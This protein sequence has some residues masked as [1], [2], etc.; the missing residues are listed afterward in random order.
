MEWHDKTCRRLD[1]A[2]FGGGTSCLSCGSVR[3][4]HPILPVIKQPSDIRILRVLPG[5]F[6]D[7]V[8]CEIQTEDLS[9]DIDYEAISYTWADETGDA[10]HCR[11]ISVSG[12]PFKITRNCEMALKRVRRQ[13]STR[14][15]WVDAICINQDDV[16]ERGH[17]VGLMP[18]IYSGA[19]NVL[20]YIGEI[21]LCS[22][23][24]K[25]MDVQK[26]LDMNF[27]IPQSFWTEM[28]SSR[29]FTRLWVL[30]EVAL[31][32]QAVL[33]FGGQS[34]SWSVV[35]NQAEQWNLKFTPSVFHFDHKAYS[36]PVQ[37]INLL[38][39]AKSCNASDPRDKIFALLGLLPSR[40]IGDI[41]ADYSLTTED[42]YTRV[43]LHLAST[44]GWL[45][46]LLNAGKDAQKD[47][48]I[49]SLPSWVPDWSARVRPDSTLAVSE[50]STIKEMKPLDCI[51]HESKKSLSL[52]LLYTPGLKPKWHRYEDYE[53]LFRVR[54]LC[55]P[56][57]L[58]GDIQLTLEYWWSIFSTSILRRPIFEL[59]IERHSQ[60]PL[61]ASE[62]ISLRS[63]DLQSQY[64]HYCPD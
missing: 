12:Q 36:T 30:Q 38:R 28:L 57:I 27:P 3:P 19:K 20:M 53:A 63:L 4:T 62:Y 8:E 46:V 61:A 41:E 52:R 18:R 17:Q 55:F 21:P 22:P 60:S 43:A 7:D 44:A 56:L 37:V 13:Y 48:G 15:I 35:R 29:Y 9:K 32:R 49:S 45:S 23:A 16:S 64:F 25:I 50:S 10:S 26:L 47:N 11:T 2:D 39:L 59:N 58:S 54:N 14:N 1:L 6:D 5:S 33:I 24:V 42:L 31:A 34:L 40:R 51:H